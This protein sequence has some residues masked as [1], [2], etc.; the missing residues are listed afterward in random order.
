MLPMSPSGPEQLSIRVD[1]AHNVSGLLLRPS[2]SRACYIFAH[3]AGAGMTHPFMQAV[4]ADL[5]DAGIATLRFQFPYME[6]GARRPDPPKL[7]HAAVQAAAAEASRRA[8]VLPV[9]AGGKSFGGCMASQA[10]AAS[11]LAGV[12]GL[13]FFGFPLHP[14]KRKSDKR[15]AHLFDIRIPMLFL[16]GTRDDLAE[17]G[18]IRQ[19]VERLGAGATLHLLQD[20]D[21]SFR[22]PRRSGRTD[23]EV[24][25]E[26]CD[27]FV[28]WSISVLSQHE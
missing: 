25:R 18:L 5:A 15:A 6:Q 11:P 2:S 28:G 12:R 17:V 19:T 24:R 3:G 9:F 16:Q 4:A 23:A 7:A 10:Q 14:A 27:V 22:V 20:A 1:A 8:G 21:H 13:A 26:M